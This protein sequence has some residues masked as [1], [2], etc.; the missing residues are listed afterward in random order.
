MQDLPEN[1]FRVCGASWVNTISYYYRGFLG[2]P[3]LALFYSLCSWMVWFTCENQL[4]K[5]IRWWFHTFAL[6]NESVSVVACL[7]RDLERMRDWATKWKVTLEPIKCKALLLFRERISTILKFYF[8]STKND[9]PE[10]THFTWRHSSQQSAV[11][12][13]CLRHLK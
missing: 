8:R 13:T 5:S 6:T 12:Q 1:H 11:D 7:N 9:I 4:Y 10:I 2:I 3:L